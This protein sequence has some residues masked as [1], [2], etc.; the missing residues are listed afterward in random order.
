MINRKPCTDKN[1][2]LAC[3]LSRSFYYLL[4][5]IYL[6]SCYLPF[7]LLI[8]LP[9]LTRLLS[10]YKLLVL[11]KPQHCRSC[12]KC[13]NTLFISTTRAN[14]AYPMYTFV[15][16][17]MP[18]QNIIWNKQSKQ[19]SRILFITYIIA[20]IFFHFSSIWLNHLQLNV[21]VL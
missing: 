11:A 20:F 7:Y 14:T 6:V 18:K 16:I 5:D 2:L 9:K 12:R 19:L 15:N 10:L 21:W 17:A 4:P 1:C 8:Y 13:K 3:L